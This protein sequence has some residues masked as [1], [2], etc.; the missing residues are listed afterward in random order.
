MDAGL[1]YLEKMLE[2]IMF[3]KSERDKYLWPRF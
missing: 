2:M 1:I 3:T